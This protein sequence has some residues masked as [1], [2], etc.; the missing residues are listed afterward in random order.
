MEGNI[1]IDK[2][3]KMLKDYADARI[4]STIADENSSEPRRNIY[5]EMKEE[6]GL[7]KEQIK[8]LQDLNTVKN[9]NNNS[10]KMIGEEYNRQKLYL[11]AKGKQL[12]IEREITDELGR[13]INQTYK[14]SKD[15]SMNLSGTTITETPEKIRINQAKELDR[16]L[17][18]I[19][20]SEENA[21]KTRI[22]LEKSENPQNSPVVISAKSLTS[23]IE[24]QTQ[25]MR[26]QQI[27]TRDSIGTKQYQT[28]LDLL[29]SQKLELDDMNKNLRLQQTEVKNLD[30]FWGNMGYQWKKAFTSFSMYLS[31]T[32]VF[33]Q[34]TR[35]IRQM[36]DE[37]VALDTSLLELRKV[38]D[39]EGDSL[40]EFI[41]QAYDA[42]EQLAK[43]GKDVIE[44]T[45]EFAKVGYD[46]NSAMKLGET[47]LMYTNIADEAISAADASSFLIAQMKAF[48]IE[49]NKSEHIIDAVNEVANKYAVSS[50]DIA[51]NLGASSSV[52]AN[53]N[54]SLEESIGLLTAGTEITRN[55]ARVSNGL[56]T[57]TL[58]LQGMN[59]EGEKDLELIPKLES[60]FNKLGLSLLDSNGELK[61]TYQ[62]LKELA[63]I[64]N[65]M[66][67][68]T[69]AYYTELIAGKY[70][71]Q[72]AAAI[73]SNFGTAVSAT[74]TAMN[75]AG[76]AGRENEKVLDSIKGKISRFQSAFQ[77]LS[78]TLVNSDV[79]K[80]IIDFSTALLKL[81]TTDSGKT[82]I[83]LSSMFLGITIL[84]TGFVALT[85]GVKK[86]AI[87]ILTA[88]LMTKGYTEEAIA[89][90][91]ANMTLSKSFA[92]LGKAA[93]PIAIAT[94]VASIL[95]WISSLDTASER[96][97]KLADKVEDATTNLQKINDELE[98]TGNRIDE[99]NKKDKL[100]F[101]E[102][103]ELKKLK[104]T[105]DQLIIQR[106]LARDLADIAA[107]KANKSFLNEYQGQLSR[108]EKVYS[109]YDANDDLTKED[110]IT[111][112]LAIYKELNA[113]KEAGKKLTQ[114][115]T[116]E[117]NAYKESL[118]KSAEDLSKLI[119][120]LTGDAQS[121]AQSIYNSITDTFYSNEKKDSIIESILDSDNPSWSTFKENLM[122]LGEDGKTS[123]KDIEGLIKEYEWLGETLNAGDI[124]WED[125]IAYIEDAD[126]QVVNVTDSLDTL[127]DEI[128]TIQGAYDTLSSAISE[129]NE[130]GYIS[131]DTLQELLTK[132][133]DYLQYLFDEQGN[134][135]LNKDAL[136]NL[137]LARIDDLKQVAAQQLLDYASTLT[138]EDEATKNLTTSA[139]EYT[140]ALAAKNSEL[141]KSIALENASSDKWDESTW[142]KFES[143]FNAINSYINQLDATA[144]SIRSGVGVISTKSSSSS[145]KSSEKE[146]WETQL[147]NLKDQF[148]YSEITIQEYINGLSSLLSQL[149]S[150]SD[151]WRE[152]NEELQKQRLSKVES[153]Y[154]NGT[155]SLE[156]Y[157]SKLKE[158]IGVYK[159]GSEAWND[160][161]EKIKSANLE[162]LEN[163]KDDYDK[164]YDAATKLIDEEI[165]K[166]NDL[167]D[168]TEKRYDEEIA[169]KQKSNEE[170]ENAIQLAELQQNLENARN[171]KN[172]RVF[173]EG[174]GW[175]WEADQEAVKNAEKEL[176]DFRNNE[177]IKQLE[178]A[179]DAELAILDEKIA[180]WETY[181]ESWSN[182]SSEYEEQQNLLMLTQQF[183]ADFESKILEQRLDA[184]Q[185]F[186]DKYIAIQ[187]EIALTEQQSINGITPSNVNTSGSSIGSA[188]TYTVK[189]G[190]NLS[191]IAGMYGVS[192]DELY[193]LNRSTIGSNKNLI[194]AG[195]NLTIPGYKDG[196]IVDY[197]GMAML[198]GTK[199]NPEYVMNN[200]QMKNLLTSLI[201]PRTTSNIGGNN[202]GSTYVYNFDNLVLPNVQNPQQFLTELK[203]FVN[204]TKHQ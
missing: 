111:K 48:N 178:D 69:K 191:R 182:I 34:T 137:T 195:Q 4:K 13:R 163:R 11:D 141:A 151:A 36:I 117:Y 25:K 7:L 102:A 68:D 113:E 179:R 45:T 91:V 136:N 189:Q 201:R 100:T 115:E 104:E 23:E 1:N 97:K 74:E 192:V 156:V 125:L 149:Q 105:N 77:E 6:I 162:L 10:I 135:S 89:A 71:A 44:A 57:I 55:A 143:K 73:L 114:E 166:I 78:T 96:T 92:I 14:I 170:T 164:A 17:T 52:L 94:A 186:K 204:I 110:K 199:T 144:G 140:A 50:A 54:N 95:L 108:K 35:S 120:N 3:T 43:T 126:N 153:D 155:I 65:T 75:S 30:K 46:P 40:D 142:A 88:T 197:T 76:S 28:N 47:A 103:D 64:Y 184:L 123:Q 169:A 31:V 138:N 171:E 121:V 53:A 188:R 200:D 9:A 198:H 119:P 99:L 180:N 194:Y 139:Q 158:L 87:N 176:E 122:Q 38:T 165:D 183:G 66:D 175:T 22:Q 5:K 130:N 101:A 62:I 39:L 41:A 128:D 174:L 83:A 58:R 42:G 81:G 84:K 70:Q 185:T 154:K 190:D 33:Y 177:E 172:K 8:L 60:N 2:L 160:L 59:D 167:R 12:K 49:A 80:F 15:S 134:L 90:E 16:I 19:N 173:R 202:S 157:I 152:I 61:S 161:A 118:L 129:Y 56:K 37:V 26:E 187:K 150:G 168:A 203:S 29:K 132:Y 72:N 112:Q 116:R 85:D 147:N 159:K 93:V 79:V 124:S 145:S 51:N 196:G 18:D 27:I 106:N 86:Y 146:W 148:K 107:S 193:N 131:I 98:T 24:T 82:I 133:P 20:K 181:K 67:A 63:P 109:G 21:Q 32:S 127:N